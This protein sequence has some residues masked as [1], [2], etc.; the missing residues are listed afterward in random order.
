MEGARASISP[1]RLAKAFYP[2]LWSPEADISAT[3]VVRSEKLQISINRDIPVSVQELVHGSKE[4][5][6]ETSSNNPVKENEL[7]SSRNGVL[8]TRKDRGT[9]K[10]LEC[11]DCEWES[12]TN[13]S[14]VQN[15]NHFVRE[16]E[17]VWPKEG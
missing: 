15:P 6:V 2:L 4:T 12:P 3:L 11:N 7:I 14:L 9:C 13:K 8:R 5:R 16:S 17:E 10:S 1:Q